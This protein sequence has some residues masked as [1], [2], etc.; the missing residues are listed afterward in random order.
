MER[1]DYDKLQTRKIK[2]LKV[3][4][5]ALFDVLRHVAMLPPIPL[6]GNNLFAIVVMDAAQKR[7]KLEDARG[8]AGGSDDEDGGD[9]EVASDDEPTPQKRTRKQQ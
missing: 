1:Q 4:K 6:A 3:L 9:D 2:A 8:G 7:K 5:V